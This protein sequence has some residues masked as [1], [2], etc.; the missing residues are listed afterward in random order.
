MKSRT[1]CDITGSQIQCSSGFH[2]TMTYC[3]NSIFLSFNL[4]IYEMSNKDNIWLVCPNYIVLRAKWDNIDIANIG[5]CL[6]FN[7][8]YL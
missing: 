5:Q 2:G 3:D 1:S 6:V 7:K 8:C 4:L